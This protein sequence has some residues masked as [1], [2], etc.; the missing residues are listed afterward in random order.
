LY[1][2][3]WNVLSLYRTGALNLLLEQLE[4]YKISIIAIQEIHGK[5][6]GLLEKRGHTTFYSCD[7][8]VHQFG[9]GFIVKNLC[10]TR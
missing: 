2:G 9:T 8:K 10:N 5:G 7:V 1:I 3:T 6:N 4:K